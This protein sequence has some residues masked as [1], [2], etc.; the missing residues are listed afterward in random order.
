MKENPNNS[1]GNSYIYKFMSNNQRKL[2]DEIRDGNDTNTQ[3]KIQV[4]T[5]IA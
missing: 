4:P 1:I 3:F 2:R 5:L